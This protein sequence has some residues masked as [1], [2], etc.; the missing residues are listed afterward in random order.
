MTCMGGTVGGLPALVRAKDDRGRNSGGVPPDRSRELQGPPRPTRH[1]LQD[2]HDRFGAIS[3]VRACGRDQNDSRCVNCALEVRVRPG[4]LESVKRFMI[5]PHPPDIVLLP[6]CREGTILAV[7]TTRPPMSC[8]KLAVPCARC[9]P[10]RCGLLVLATEA[11]APTSSPALKRLPSE[12]TLALSHGNG[13]PLE[14]EPPFVVKPNPHDKHF[15]GVRPSAFVMSRVLRTL[16]AFGGS[17]SPTRLQL[18]AR[19]NYT[20][21]ERYVEYMVSLGFLEVVTDDAH[22]RRRIQ[23]TPKGSGLI[24][25]PG[26][27]VDTPPASNERESRPDNRIRG[28]L[29][30]ALRIGTTVRQTQEARSSS[31]DSR[32]DQSPRLPVSTNHTPGI[33]RFRARTHRTSR[34]QRP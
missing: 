19:M 28:H 6:W 27:P 29:T 12:E 13:G 30:S 21:S 8:P 25:P 10:A 20:Q 14:A 3:I 15:H 7:I 32:P 33:R 34:A 23:L 17:S 26:R 4:R 18:A 24:E 11:E 31:D 16:E 22:G 2:L 5:A 9:D 1:W